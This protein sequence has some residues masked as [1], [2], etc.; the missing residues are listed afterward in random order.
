MF[1]ISKIGF[2]FAFDLRKMNNNSLHIILLGIIILLRS[3]R[4]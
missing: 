2:I 3:Q 1:D 4:V